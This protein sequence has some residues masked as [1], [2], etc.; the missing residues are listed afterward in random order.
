MHSANLVLN[1]PLSVSRATRIA[2][3]CAFLLAKLASGFS[4]C[5]GKGLPTI[6]QLFD[7]TTL[8]AFAHLQAKYSIEANDLFDF[9]DT[10]GMGQN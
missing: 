8:R 5:A 10:Q 4:R 7:R 2:A 1:L 9:D 3:V 6:N